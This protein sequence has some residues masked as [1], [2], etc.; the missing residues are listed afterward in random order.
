MSKQL[1]GQLSIFDLSEFEYKL[2]A[3]YIKIF[4]IKK[5]RNYIRDGK[6]EKVI[7]YMAHLG[8]YHTSIG[9]SE[10]NHTILA[11]SPKG[12]QF[13]DEEY[14]YPFPTIADMLIQRYRNI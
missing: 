8:K 11:L 13:N 7:D 1:K 9:W 12:L 2:E 5:F 10:R 6:R 14:I 4:D 3:V